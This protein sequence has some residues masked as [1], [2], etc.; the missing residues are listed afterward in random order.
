MKTDYERTKEFLDSLGILYGDNT[1]ERYERYDIHLNGIRKHITFG[2]PSYGEDDF[3][4]CDKVEGYSGFFTEFTF[5]ESG[6]FLT[7]GSWE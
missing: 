1:R 3:L 6:K 2:S 5:D 7:V 4:E